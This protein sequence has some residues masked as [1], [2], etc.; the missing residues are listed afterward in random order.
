MDTRHLPVSGVAHK[1]SYPCPTW[2]YH[3]LWLSP[4]VCTKWS[5]CCR[6]HFHGYLRVFVFWLKFH[7]SSVLMVWFGSSLGAEQATSH[8]LNYC[9]PRSTAKFVALPVGHNELLISMGYNWLP[10]MRHN[11]SAVKILPLF[12]QVGWYRVSLGPR[13]VFIS[14]V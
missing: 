1:G 2:A 7:L 5:P 12:T 8:Y 11:T 6:R 4:E 14:W 10:G 3:N 9:R 13:G